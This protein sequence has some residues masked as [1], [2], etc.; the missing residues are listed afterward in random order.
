MPRPRYLL[1]LIAVLV[2]VLATVF[3]PVIF[4]SGR[5]QPASDDLRGV[6][7]AF[8]PWQASFVSASTG[9]VLGSVDCRFSILNPRPGC[10]PVIVATS[11]GGQH[12]RTLSAPDG[13]LDEDPYN[14][15]FTGITFANARDGWLYGTTLWATHDGG[16]HWTRIHVSGNIVGLVASGQWAYA[17]S[18]APIDGPVT[19]LRSAV[20]AN[21]WQRP[22][23]LPA[24]ALATTDVEDGGPVLTTYG[25]SAW[26]GINHT[27]RRSGVTVDQYV[28]LWRTSDGVHWTRIGNP[29]GGS[30]SNHAPRADVGTVTASSSSDL[31]LTCFTGDQKAPAYLAIS[32]DGA[33]HVHVLHA[34]QQLSREIAVVTPSSPPDR[35]TTVVFAYPAS[36]LQEWQATHA[37]LLHG[38][39]ADTAN[40]GRTWT[41]TTF[42]DRGAGWSPLQFVSPTVGWAIHGAPGAPIDQIMRTTNAGATFRPVG[43]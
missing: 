43:S 35:A 3:V 15:G 25:N 1:P 2:F 5:A 31:V 4:R 6:S 21:N 26:A 14:G 36:W 30:P 22:H 24:G 9:F 29:C 13:Q 10:R 34:T 20:G 37:A 11:D 27:Y 28:V 23:G 12:W 42:N 41:T 39:L 40:D 18:Q 32:G 7:A 33:V 19:L 8:E 16:N 17:A 38:A